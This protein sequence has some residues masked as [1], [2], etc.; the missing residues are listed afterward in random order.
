MKFQ[1]ELKILQMQLSSRNFFDELIKTTLCKFYWKD[2]CKNS[3]NKIKKVKKIEISSRFFSIFLS[4]FKKLSH[5]YSKLTFKSLKLCLG[6]H[7][8]LWG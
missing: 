8:W 5:D 4:L 7:T 6:H 2:N 3:M 1:L